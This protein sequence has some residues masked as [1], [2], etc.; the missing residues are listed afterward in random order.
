MTSDLT[1]P[2]RK[3]FLKSEVKEPVFDIIDLFLSLA[4]LDDAFDTD[5]I[6]STEDIFRTRVEPPRRSLELKF[7]AEILNVP[8][9]RQPVSTPLGM[10]TDAMKPLK[11]HTYLHFLQR[12]S[13]AVGRMRAMKPYE[14]RRG[15]GEAVNSKSHTTDA[16]IQF[17]QCNTSP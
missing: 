14:L 16:I 5:F 11:Y 2:Q 6:Q 8:I 12:L 4:I 9:C 13:L 15:T 3:I 17:N 7:K 1:M 10:S